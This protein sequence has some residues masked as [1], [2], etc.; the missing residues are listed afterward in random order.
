MNPGYDYNQILVEYEQLMGMSLKAT[1]LG[2]LPS[3]LLNVVVFVFTALALYTI[4][5]RRGIHRPWLAWIPIVD[6]YLLGCIADQY[7]AVACKETKNRR[8]ILLGL[9]IAM[10]ILSIVTV[11]LSIVFVLELLSLGLGNLE[12]LESMTE[13]AAT[14]LLASLVGPAM[15]MLLTSI[16]L[17]AVGITFLVFY[18]IA[19]HDIY[20]SCDPANA[21]LFT[22]LSI[23]FSISLPI[24][25]FFVCRNRDDGMPTRQEEPPQLPLEPWEQE[26]E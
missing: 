26:R 16:P 18:S 22:V 23:L 7:R 14:A 12:A 2:E 24:F 20:K 1:I 11:V 6:A 25:L 19:L 5:K 13:S 3:I 8:K 4:A 17:L 9:Q 15:G 21:T 10:T